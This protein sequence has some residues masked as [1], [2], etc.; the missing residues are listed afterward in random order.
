MAFV[1][2]F[3]TVVEGEQQVEVCVN[4]TE[5]QVD[6]LDEYVRVE[7]FDDDTSVYIPPGAVLASE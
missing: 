3:Y 5:P 4:L 1:Q 7:A 2:T 6:I